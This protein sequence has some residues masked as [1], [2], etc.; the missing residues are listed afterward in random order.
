MNYTELHLH[1]HYSLMDGLN[2]PEEYMKRAKELGM[3]HIAITDHG[4]LTGHR[5]FQK[6]AQKA[7]ITPILGVEAY[8]S[9]TDRFDRRSVKKRDDNT[10]AYN[11]MGIL[12]ANETG[13]LNLHRLQELAW[14]EGFYSKPRID[15]EILEQYN[16]GLIVLSGCMTGL[17]SKALEKN[18]PLQAE[19]FTRQLKDI[20]GDRFFMEIQG[21]NSPEL[22]AGLLKLAGDYKVKPVVTSDCHYARKED[23]W[24]E[25]AMLIL[26]TGAK[27]NHKADMSKAEKMGILER[28]NYLWPERP[29]TFEQ[30]EIYLRSATEQKE[31]LAVQGLGTEAIENTMLVAEMIET[32]PLKSGLDLLP[33][34]VADPNK[35]LREKVIAGAKERGTYGIPEYDARR[36]EELATIAQLDF[37][38]Y[39][40]PLAN[41][42]SWSKNKGI[43]VGPGRGSGAGS[44]V[45]YEL[46]L[47]AVDPIKYNLLFSRFLDPSRPDPPDQDTD[48]MASRRGEVKNY[49]RKTYGNVASIM[50]F[51]TFGGKKSIRDASRVFGIP[52]GEVNR[53]LKGA[54][55]LSPPFDW[56]KEWER[57]EKGRAFIKKYPEVVRL[58]RALHG[59]IRETGVHA[60]GIVLCKDE[61]HKYA[62]IQTSKDPNDENAPRITVAGIDMNDAAEI[63]FIKYDILGLKALDIVDDTVRFVKERHGID[64]DMESLPLDNPR[65]YATLSEGYTQAVFQCEQAPYTSLLIDMGGVKNFE[66]LAASNAL[67]RPGASKSTAGKA[68]IARKN[69][70]QKVTYHHPE[71]EPLTNETYG[72]IIYQEQV[73][74]AIHHIGGLSMV[75]ANAIRRIIGK[76][77]DVSEFDAYKRKFIE[78]ASQKISP[79]LAETLWHDFEAHA[80]YSFNKSHAVAY[81]ML[82]YWTAW[83]KEEYPLE[84]MCAVLRNETDKDRFLEYLIEAR[85]LGL[86]IK[87]PH[88]NE[89]DT[90]FSIGSDDRGD[91]LRFGLENVKGIAGK[92]A[93]RLV[94]LR[95]FPNYQTL[96]EACMEKGSGLST[97][98]LQGLN[99]IGGAEFPDNPRHGK[100]KENLYEYLSIPS[101]GGEK[102]PPKMTQRFW[103]LDEYSENET[104][105]TL[106]MVRKVKFGDGWARVDVADETGTAG[107][108]A[109]PETQIETG[110]QYVLLVSN[111]RIVRYITTKEIL[112]GADSAFVD[113]LMTDGYP[114]VPPGMY[115]V[116]HFNSRTTKAGKKMGDVVLADEHKNLIG[117]LVWPSGWA[118]AYSKCKPGEVL[119]IQI[120]ETEDGAKFVH[121]IL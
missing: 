24:V 107:I 103:T 47:H 71:L 88:V 27:F 8:I 45:G 92:T 60:G 83:L 119:D 37:S 48:F 42:V 2:T 68:F 36:E 29:I 14:T 23:L 31:L 91:Y 116:I 64:L 32:I 54:D 28:F 49:F 87:L 70:K 17:I 22:N 51:G 117:A 110:S 81:S 73:M 114:D 3:S 89:S 65:V 12:V 61:I 46:F 101:F 18:Q 86:R 34:K 1:T 106:A 19:Q 111:N 55:W 66:E 112:E 50:T 100:E 26:S 97:R 7:G 96:Y 40:I 41:A 10:S 62:S 30:I 105:V 98:V 76:K 74:Q 56:W 52:L 95:P 79:E 94:A 113:F 93:A 53:A 39:F 33:S 108:F 77:K 102:L 13:L 9:A 15:L 120:K 72:T 82:S 43:R 25:E 109:H 80:G 4:T 118:K 5:D 85:R 84:F 69:G 75:E 59:R 21:H 57:T 121:N 44:L 63:G 11:H 115:K 6:Q 67:V 20:F 58:A 78:G 38:T 35:L 90:R 16:E 104:F 99:A